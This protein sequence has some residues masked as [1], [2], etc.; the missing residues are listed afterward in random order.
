MLCILAAPFHDIE[1]GSLADSEIKG[2]SA[3]LRPSQT[4]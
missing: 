1:R 2:H 3:V 4:T